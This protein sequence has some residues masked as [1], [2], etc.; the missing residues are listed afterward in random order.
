MSDAI[1][2]P[3]PRF[4][5]TCLLAYVEGELSA[6]EAA[7]LEAEARQQ[8]AL[9]AALRQLRADRVAIRAMAE[10]APPA[11]MVEDVLGLVERSMLLAEDPIAPTVHVQRRSAFANWQRY[12]VA[13]GFILLVAGAGSFI[14]QTLFLD[15]RGTEFFVEGREGPK[16]KDRGAGDDATP[17]DLASGAPNQ[18]DEVAMPT[19]AEEDAARDRFAINDP[20]DLEGE[21]RLDRSV[22]I[23]TNAGSDAA[24]PDLASTAS[25]SESDGGSVAAEDLG[26]AIDVFTPDRATALDVLAQNLSSVAGGEVVINWSLD[27]GAQPALVREWRTALAG[28]QALHVLPGGV[29]SPW[30][31]AARLRPWP[32]LAA[33]AQRP[34]EGVPLEV[35]ARHLDEGFELTLVGPPSAILRAVRELHTVRGQHVRWLKPG[36]GATLESLA[37]PNWP[38]GATDWDRVLAWWAADEADAL[39]DRLAISLAAAQGVDVEPIVR[40]PLRFTLVDPPPPLRS[41]PPR[42]KPDANDV[43]DNE[44]SQRASDDDDADRNG[45][46]D[47]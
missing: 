4:D 37:A 35:Q 25:E 41:R 22:E 24:R 30:P 19:P 32:S 1:P 36:S 39:L 5:E 27:P 47:R 20:L 7:R 31:N 46:P 23:A 45:D 28:V 2:Q 38:G 14:A 6:D 10:P 16:P 3:G 33:Q 11:G 29:R 26:I 18:G 17:P 12:A 42:T 8:P 9:M 40:V 44:K 15:E 21:A 34:S 43:D 13:A